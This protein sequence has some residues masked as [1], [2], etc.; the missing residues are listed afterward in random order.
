[1]STYKNNDKD[2]DNGHENFW[3]VCVCVVKMTVVS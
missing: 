3:W 1:M 2:N